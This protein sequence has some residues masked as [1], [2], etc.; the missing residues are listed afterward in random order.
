M[1]DRPIGYP[2]GKGGFPLLVLVRVNSKKVIVV[3]LKVIMED[4]D[5]FFR[6]GFKGQGLYLGFYV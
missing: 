2:K 5:D 3:F 6:S 4:F 1:Y